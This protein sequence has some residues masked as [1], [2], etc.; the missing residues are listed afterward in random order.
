MKQTV[1]VRLMHMRMAV[2][3]WILPLVSLITLSMAG[4]ST[5]FVQHI[6]IYARDHQMGFDIIAL[7]T[8]LTGISLAA[9][10]LTG[11]RKHLPPHY[12][13]HARAGVLL[14]VFVAGLALLSIILKWRFGGL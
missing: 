12:L 8:F 9:W 2:A 13:Q 11:G 1:T 5:L 14:A 3:A 10:C 6:P 7:S 4:D